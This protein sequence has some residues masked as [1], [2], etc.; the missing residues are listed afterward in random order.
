MMESYEYIKEQRESGFQVGDHCIVTSK[1]IPGDYGWDTTHLP[2]EKD[3]N[4]E[5]FEMNHS[6]LIGEHVFIVAID[7][8]RIWVVTEED[9]ENSRHWDF[10]HYALKKHPVYLAFDNIDTQ[11][12]VEHF[13][14]YLMVGCCVITHRKLRQIVRDAFPPKI[15]ETGDKR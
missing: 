9:E 7:L 13:D 6:Q 12:P 5:Q 10:P 15:E 14:G 4:Q 2:H 8:D 3:P 1:V 11:V